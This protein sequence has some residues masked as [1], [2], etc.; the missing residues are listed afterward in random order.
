[1]AR[2]VPKPEVSVVIKA[3]IK[4]NFVNLNFKIMS[5]FLFLF[6]GGVM[7]ARNQSTPEESRTYGRNGGAGWAD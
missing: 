2:Y 6:R 4:N 1:M 7:R 3:N 5:N